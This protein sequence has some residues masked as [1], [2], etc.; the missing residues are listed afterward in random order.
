MGVSILVSSSA[1]VLQTLAAPVS[2]LFVEGMFLVLLSS[3]VEF[4]WGDLIAAD[5]RRYSSKLV[6]VKYVQ[7]GLGV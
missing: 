7:L 3:W 1:L 4:V 6:I 5:Q 2:K